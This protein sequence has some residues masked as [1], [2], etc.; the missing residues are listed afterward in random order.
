MFLK[1]VSFHLL[2]RATLAG[3]ER[4]DGKDGG[5]ERHWDTER[6]AMIASFPK[7][8]KQPAPGQ[9]HA[10]CQDR[11]KVSSCHLPRYNSS[12]AFKPEPA[13]TWDTDTTSG[14]LGCCT[15][16]LVHEVKIIFHG[17]SRCWIRNT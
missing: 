12:K 15:T 13:P 7:C 9:A 6:S 17:L 2:E 10:R 5:R 3:G 16:I 11:P 1:T 14:G 4:D 8:S